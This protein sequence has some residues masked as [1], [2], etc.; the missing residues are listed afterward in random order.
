MNTFFPFFAFFRFGVVLVFSPVSKKCN[1]SL[2]MSFFWPTTTQVSFKHLCT[3]TPHTFS[4]QAI[5]FAELHQISKIEFV[6][7]ALLIVHSLF[8]CF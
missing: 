7:E 6:I 1:I 5:I 8:D 4:F 3:G 2:M